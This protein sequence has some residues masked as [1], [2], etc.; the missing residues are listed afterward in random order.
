MLD[1]TERRRFISGEFAKLRSELA[2]GADQRAAES[3]F[4]LAQS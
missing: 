3:V 4:E 1:D 2:L